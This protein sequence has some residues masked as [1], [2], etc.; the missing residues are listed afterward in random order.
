MFA[1]AWS[2]DAEFLA[3]Y[4][5]DEGGRISVLDFPGREAMLAVFGSAGDPYS[6]LEEYLHLDSGI[7]RSPYELMTFYDNHDMTRIDAD[8]N[9][10]INA[11]NWLFTSR[12]IPV[13]YYGSEIAFRAG[14]DQ[15]SGNRDYFGQ[16]NVELAK[17]HPIHAAM[18]RIA[19]VR[20]ESIALQRGLQVNIDLGGDTAAFYRVYQ[21]DGE[22]QTALVLLNKG[23][24][25][26]V[27]ENIKWLDDGA[28][29]DAISGEV[30]EVDGDA[31]AIDVA[32]HGV[33]VL[34]RNEPVE[35]V[36]LV[37]ELARLQAI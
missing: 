19:A 29:R 13:V 12:G 37:A 27:F 20:N 28:W 1:E 22:N 2:Y 16:D 18:K 32:A 34:L 23:K 9:G 17:S 14:A 4:T 33:R 15:H 11:N 10:F 30:L 6:A 36:E 21:K 5:Y 26:T 31:A 8:Q 24:T 3:H 35:N 7:Y 25:G